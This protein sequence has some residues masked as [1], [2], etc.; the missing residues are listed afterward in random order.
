MP[1]SKGKPAVNASR[2]YV[3]PGASVFASDDWIVRYFFPSV[4][5]M[6]Q[7]SRRVREFCFSSG[8]KTAVLALFAHFGLATE[9]MLNLFDGTCLQQDSFCIN[10]S[11]A[12]KCLEATCC[13]GGLSPRLSLS[14]DHPR[15]LL[16]G[17]Y[18]IFRSFAFAC[19]KDPWMDIDP[20]SRPDDLAVAFV[21]N[22]QLASGRAPV[23]LPREIIFRFRAEAEI[24][25]HFD[26]ILERGHRPN[27]QVKFKFQYRLLWAISENQAVV[28]DIRPERKEDVMTPPEFT[29]LE[30]KEDVMRPTEFTDRVIHSVLFCYFELAGVTDLPNPA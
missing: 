12:L 4:T 3:P 14:N 20:P 26:G 10:V 23:I 22:I 8:R 11:E 7:P 25:T 2:K 27:C 28:Q 18:E 1:Q 24:A 16:S 6:T 17:F 13:L 19:S 30:W 21:R 15:E 5:D 29:R 9:L